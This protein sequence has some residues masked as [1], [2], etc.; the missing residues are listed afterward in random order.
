MLI[1]AVL[2]RSHPLNNAF[3]VHNP[4]WIGGTLATT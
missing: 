3:K 1:Y 4:H 2:K